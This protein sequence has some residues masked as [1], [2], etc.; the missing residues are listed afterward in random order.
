VKNRDIW[1]MSYP[2]KALWRNLL[3]AVAG[4]AI[5]IIIIVP[6]GVFGLFF[7]FADGPISRSQEIVY[8]VLTTIGVVAGTFAGGYATAR[9]SIGTGIGPVVLTGASLV[10]FYLLITNF[11][12]TTYG[13]DEI[14]HLLIILPSTIIGG[15]QG[16]RKKKSAA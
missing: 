1:F 5:A 14:V 11:D 9:L 15:Y 7:V 3:S 2:N 16:L 13:T 4:T 6:T 8:Y 12:V 10:C